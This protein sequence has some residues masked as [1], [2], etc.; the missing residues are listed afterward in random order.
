MKGTTTDL[1]QKIIGP[2]YEAFQKYLHD[3]RLNRYLLRSGVISLLA[4]PF[5]TVLTHLTG[6]LGFFLRRIYYAQRVKSLGKNTLI[7]V[8]VA[9]Y[10][11]RNIQIGEFCWIDSYTKLIAPY[12]HINIGKR[13]HVSTGVY[14]SG[15]GGINIEDYAGIAPNAIILSSTEYPVPGKRMSGPMLPLEY[16]GIKQGPVILKKDSF[17]GS[18]SIVMPGVVIGEGAIVAA[19]SVANQNVAPYTIVFGNPARKIRSRS[20]ITVPDI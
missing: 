7:D 9:M 1:S 15:A 16:R 2:E 13:V 11:P 4:D 5:I 8:G 6:P 19:N 17:V 10:G 14:L 20:P 3:G 12:G 18:N